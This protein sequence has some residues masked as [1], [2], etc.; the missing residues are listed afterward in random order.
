MPLH[1]GA[2]RGVPR[3]STIEQR[4]S[5]LGLPSPAAGL[6]DRVR[7]A[8]ARVERALAFARE[9]GQGVRQD[10]P[11][12]FGRPDAWPE[13]AREHDLMRRVHLMERLAHE[14]GG[15]LRAVPADPLTEVL[16][17]LDALDLVPLAD[18][19]TRTQQLAEALRRAPGQAA[20]PA[21]M[22]PGPGP[23]APASPPAPRPAGHTSPPAGLPGPSTAP[24]AKSAMSLGAIPPRPAAGQD[25]ALI[26]GLAPRSS[27]Q[28]LGPTP[29]RPAAAPPRPGTGGLRPGGL[30]RSPIPPRPGAA[31]MDEAA[32]QGARKAFDQAVKLAREVLAYV[33]P[34]LTL[35]DVALT[36][37]G[38]PTAPRPWPLIEPALAPAAEQAAVAP[39]LRPWLPI[40]AQLFLAD[41]DA[42][43]KTHQAI[44]QWKQ[45]REL[46][47]HADRV[48]A[49]L[50]Q[51]P[52]VSHPALLRSFDA[53]RMRA[54]VYP[55]SHLHL[56]FQGVPHL[57][58]IFPPPP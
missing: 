6:E 56:H 42:T 23:A 33:S 39:P 14:I 54:S 55:L 24:Q 18:A 8:R 49:Q 16:R 22:A 5:N 13:A 3:R 58:T 34:R 37:T 51:A 9:V 53:P 36:A 15:A 17:Q 38:L 20:G 11:D 27:T 29:G 4:R 44:T 52:P 32:V 35:A 31:P 1:A 10:F 12:V 45:A 2:Q 21:S 48:E 19:A 47:H 26:R 25:V 50:A 41:R 43:R 30:P 28:Q 57:S 46:H 7:R 40:L